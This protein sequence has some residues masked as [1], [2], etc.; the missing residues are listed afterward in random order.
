[1][2][3]R[4]PRAL[5]PTA[6]APPL[7]TT[8]SPS[9]NS[10]PVRLGGG[11]GF[12]VFVTVGTTSFSP[13]VRAAASPTFLTAVRAA[14]LIGRICIQHGRGPPP[15]GS[16]FSDARV[17]STNFS[18]F[19]LKDDIRGDMDV[20]RCVVSHAGAG[21][22]FEALR[23]GKPLCVVVNDALAGNHQ[24]ELARALDAGRHAARTQGVLTPESLAAGLSR[25][26]K[27]EWLPLPLPD[28]RRFTH[29]VEELCGFLDA[30]GGDPVPWGRQSAGVAA[31]DVTSSMPPPTPKRR[32]AA[33]PASPAAVLRRK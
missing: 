19:S 16:A 13:L 33:S 6:R 3:G 23:G 31:L 11:S 8:H 12:A 1:M 18:F 7:S 29:L 24:D 15:D 25:A 17:F 32:R 22:C 20:S 14:G 26:M 28:A 21:S 30:G 2:P 10:S 27:G 9:N 4:R 5:S